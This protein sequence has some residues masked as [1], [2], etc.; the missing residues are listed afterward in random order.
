MLEVGVA[1]RGGR[2]EKLSTSVKA[3]EG[4]RH[5]VR[6]ASGRGVVDGRNVRKE[7][8]RRVREAVGGRVN[9]E[10]RVDATAQGR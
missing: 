9:A 3:A 8:T 7:D 1:A 6:N 4:G 2:V 5:A 10:K